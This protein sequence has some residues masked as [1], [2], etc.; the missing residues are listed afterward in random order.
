M[1]KHT[2]GAWGFMDDA[3]FRKP[4][5]R[6]AAPGITISSPS[7]TEPICRVSGYL[8]PLEANANLISAAPDLLRAVLLLTKA[9]CGHCGCDRH[10]TEGCSQCG[11]IRRGKQAIAKA[12]GTQ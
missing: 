10:S 7:N 12:E 8:Q 2:P 4:A 6:E 5:F 11:L 3:A 1:T 9:H